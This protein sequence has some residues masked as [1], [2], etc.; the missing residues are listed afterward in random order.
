MSC[1]VGHRLGLD[2]VLLLL[3]CRLAATAPIQPLAWESSYA[4]S[5]ALKRL[6]KKKVPETSYL[7]SLNH[8]VPVSR[9]HK[10]TLAMMAIIYSASFGVIL[11]GLG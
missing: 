10:P 1:G 7:L 9:S 6:K 5:A 8:Q 3:W 11:Y 4:E 2:L